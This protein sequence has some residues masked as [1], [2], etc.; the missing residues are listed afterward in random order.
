MIPSLPA[1]L[2]FGLPAYI[3]VAL[4][5]RAAQGTVGVVDIQDLLDP[6]LQKPL[7]SPDKPRSSSKPASKHAPWTHAPECTHSTSFKNLGSKYCLYTNK[8][9]FIN[10]ISILTTPKTAEE[11]AQHLN[12]E[13]LSYFLSVDEV[14]E[15][16]DQESRPWNIVDVPGKDL[17]VVA[18]R[19]IKRYETFMVDQANV[20]MDLEMEK[21]VS[22]KDN[23]RLLKKAVDRLNNP[24]W[25]R[26]L[27]KK[28][29]GHAEDADEVE[30]EGAME[31]H[32]MM[33][34]AFGTQLGDVNFR[35]L[36]PLVSVSPL[37]GTVGDPTEIDRDKA[38]QPCLRSE[39]FC[40]VL[41]QR[42][43]LGHK[44]VQRYRARRRDNNIL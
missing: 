37:L 3:L 8:N 17:G 10:G 44:S 34:N 6:D 28:H 1:L 27:S 36:F 16:F 5:S 32:I 22:K 39:C 31:E 13:P 41:Q 19:K 42:V 26:Q 43:L 23:L 30:E 38:N 40:Y 2:R 7:A 15:W 14:N 33:T 20:V 24:G 9:A 4:L 35:G 18:T 25:V 11:A 21:H 29:D 12:E